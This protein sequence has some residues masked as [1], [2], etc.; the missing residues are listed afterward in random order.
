MIKKIGIPAVLNA[1]AMYDEREIPD[2]CTG[3]SVAS[4][5]FRNLL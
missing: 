3:A 5:E 1:A 4:V 2:R